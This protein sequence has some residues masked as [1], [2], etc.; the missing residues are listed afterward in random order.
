MASAA[1]Q[2]W[3][4]P[5]IFHTKTAFLSCPGL[6]Q[7]THRAGCVSRVRPPLLVLAR[8]GDDYGDRRRGSDSRGPRREGR[9]GRDNFRGGDRFR[10][11]DDRSPRNDRLGPYTR[12]DT[13][14]AVQNEDEIM[15]LLG[16]REIARR[17]GDYS[18]ADDLRDDLLFRL[19][20][21]VNDKS[22]MCLL[23]PSLT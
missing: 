14:E 3:S 2:G 16:N 4:V 10:G 11:G 13:G 1:V 22:A 21:H 7:N 6:L 19:G 9:G 23:S 12:G 20:V 18:A 15:E 8:F 5:G 17:N